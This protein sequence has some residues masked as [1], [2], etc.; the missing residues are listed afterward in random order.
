MQG[1]DLKTA[2]QLKQRARES[3]QLLVARLV[4]LSSLR[5]YN[6]DRYSHAG[7]AFELTE[8]ESDRALREFHLEEFGQ[9]V[10]RSLADLVGEMESY[11]RSLQEPI[12]ATISVW[13]DLESFRAVLPRACHPLDRDLFLS[14]VRAA[15]AVLAESGQLPSP[16]SQ[17]SSPPL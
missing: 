10:E 2:E 14:N 13:R 4:Y 15:L 5:D 8:E 16:A 9:L 17:S 11:F 3:I 7:W 1:A 12:E 6:T